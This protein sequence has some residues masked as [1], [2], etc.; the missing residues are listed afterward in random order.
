M[1]RFEIVGNN[2]LEWV[3]MVF[4]GCGRD[5]SRPYNKGKHLMEVCVGGTV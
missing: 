4:L 5:K 1:G 3:K 2:F